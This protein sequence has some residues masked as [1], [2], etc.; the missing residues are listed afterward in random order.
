MAKRPNPIKDRTGSI[1]LLELV[2]VL[3]IFVLLF[4]GFF[5]VWKLVSVRQS[6]GAATYHAARCR[7]LYHDPDRPDDDDPTIDDDGYR[8]EWTLLKELESNSFIDE[9][10][11]WGVQIR[12]RNARGD[13]ICIVTARE[14]N[15]PDVRNVC[16]NGPTSLACGERFDA[17]AALYVPWPVF[18]TVLSSE[19][20]A[21]PRNLTLVARHRSFIEC[22]PTWQP[23]PT[24]TP[25]PPTP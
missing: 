11:L 14:M 22:D 16:L 18:A 5:E 25:E 7:S 9:E 21:D 13:V 24:P 12:Y 3:P 15:S 20:D 2:F 23:T 8:C 17:E 4:Y 10:D 19:G 6:L 1:D